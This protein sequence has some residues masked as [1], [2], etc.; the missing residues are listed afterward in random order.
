M[1]ESFQEL[2][3]RKKEKGYEKSVKSLLIAA[4]V[5][6]GIGALAV[7]PVLWL[8]VLAGAAAVYFAVPRLF[9]EYEYL[10]VG[11][12]LQIDVIYSREKRKKLKEI[13][14]RECVVMAP[15]G[16]HEL[17]SY[18]RFPLAD[19]SAADPAAPAYVLVYND[20]G[21]QVRCKL[22]LSGE[23]LDRVKTIIG[24]RMRK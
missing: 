22:Q 19:Y 8:I 12:D 6:A 1:E 15:E 3:V 24:I 17:D 5:I 18:A 10:L 13:D 4:C 11:N 16:S 21:G 2:L 23:M 9:V 14:L 7:S 20:K